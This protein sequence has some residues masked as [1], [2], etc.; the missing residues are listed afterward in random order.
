MR[1]SG[2]DVNSWPALRPSAR[3]AYRRNA[4]TRRRA[5][6]GNDDHPAYQEQQYLSGALLR[7][8]ELS[9]RRG[10][11]NHSPRARRRGP[12]VPADGR[13]RRGRLRQLIRW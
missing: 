1:M 10:S 11:P 9:V 2:P 13:A 3:R 12:H 7:S 6:A 4:G 8:A 5:A